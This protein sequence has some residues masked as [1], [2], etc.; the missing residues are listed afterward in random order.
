[1]R[2]AL[3][4]SDPFYLE[5]SS[6][7]GRSISRNA[8][9]VPSELESGDL[10]R[11]VDADSREKRSG[12]INGLSIQ[13]QV[14]I[15]SA[16]VVFGAR[17]IDLGPPNYFQDGDRCIGVLA[18]LVPKL[19]S[20]L[21]SGEE[22]EASTWSLVSFRPCVS[23]LAPTDARPIG[24]ARKPAPNRFRTVFVDTSAGRSLPAL[25]PLASRRS[26]CLIAPWHRSDTVVSI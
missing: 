11:P 24:H 25:C 23:G 7:K 9:S 14:P 19:F 21:S 10:G 6:R 22:G 4:H 13:T 8:L 16:S 17:D 1:M 5:N 26:P 20:A 3:I 12:R 15:L 18:R 2:L